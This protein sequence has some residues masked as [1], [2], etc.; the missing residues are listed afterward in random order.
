MEMYVCRSLKLLNN[1][2]ALCKAIELFDADANINETVNTMSGLL[3]NDL[4]VH[5]M[6][7]T[8]HKNNSYIENVNKLVEIEK[9]DDTSMSIF[10]EELISLNIYDKLD[11][12]I[13][14]DPNQNYEIFAEAINY[15]REKHL[16]KKK[17][18]CKK[19]IHEKNC[20]D[21]K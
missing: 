18:K 10:A 3:I 6:N 16:P 21:N 19:S 20:M 1:A 17:V 11:Q 2:T 4:S 9:R 12:N 7:F 14:N 15:A 5:K 8:W 13:A